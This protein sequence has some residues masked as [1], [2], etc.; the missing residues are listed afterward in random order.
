MD[1][2]KE[3]LSELI[4]KHSEGSVSSSVSGAGL[5]A[6]NAWFYTNVEPSIFHPTISIVFGQGGHCGPRPFHF[7]GSR[8]SAAKSYTPA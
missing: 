5:S 6:R 2:T 1:L 4:C 7:R 3:Q 8:S